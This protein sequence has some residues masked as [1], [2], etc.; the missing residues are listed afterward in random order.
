MLK[1]NK[2]KVI[3]S[4]IIILLPILFGILMWNDLPD[5]ITTHWGA[6]G[7]ADGFSGKVFAVFGLPFIHL[8]LHFVCLLFTSLDKKQKEQNQKALGMIFWI[9]PV[10][11]LFTNG[12]MYRAA[13]GKEFDLAFFMPALLGVMFIFIGNYLPKVKQNRTLGIKI[14]WALNNEENW[15]KTHRFGG[16]V[17]VVGGLILLLSIFLPL[18]VMVSV[19]VC[20]IAASAII[21]I[22]YSYSIYKQHQKEGIVYAE[23]PKSGAEKIA[24][25]I[26]AVIVPVILL[27][28]TLLMFT[29]D[30]EV[31]CEDTALT[32]NATYW[33]D[34]EIDYSDID[35]IDYRKNLDVGVR[36]SGFGSPRLSMGIFRNDEFGSY[37]LY[38]Y[39]GAK[40]Y[41][42]LTSGEKTLVIGMSDTEETQEIYDAM[43]EKVRK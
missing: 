4:S 41:I 23:A 37:T 42:V 25:R 34:V 11:S 32:I 14:S 26:T 2:F 30:I 10:I 8:V 43:I 9:L 12:I 19:V 21:P 13:F 17:W 15:N 35:T 31:K 20:V 33:T 39:T 16:K 6:D 40:E 3:I 36:T 27:G 24:L 5:I 1:K 28:V 7:N 18:K 22:V 38:S 29:G